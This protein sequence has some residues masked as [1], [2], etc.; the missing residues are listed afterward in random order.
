M[1]F[2]AAPNILRVPGV[3]GL[4]GTIAVNGVVLPLMMEIGNGPLSLLGM[5]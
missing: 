5:D 4:S 1:G 3:G 2:I